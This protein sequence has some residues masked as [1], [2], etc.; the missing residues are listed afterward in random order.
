MYQTDAPYM[1]AYYVKKMFAMEKEAELIGAR[2]KEHAVKTHDRE[3]N[4]KVLLK[5]Y[6]DIL[7]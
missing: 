3:Q 6:E 1:L 4:I 7:K 2:A 5:I